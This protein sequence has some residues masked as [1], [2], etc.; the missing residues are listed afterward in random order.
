MLHSQCRSRN[1]VTVLLLAF[2]LLAS[3]TLAQE[4]KPSEPKFSAF[5][6]GSTGIFTLT[7]PSAGPG[8]AQIG[9]V[10]GFEDVYGS[11]SGITFGIEAGI[12]P[13]D[14]G[15]FLVFKAR[16]WEKT[17]SPAISG[18][19]AFSGK[20]DWTQ[21]FYSF[22][23]RYFFVNATSKTSKV[24][25]FAGAGYIKAEAAERVNGTI[26]S[27][28]PPQ[29][30]VEESFVDGS[31]YYL[32]AGVTSYL[33]RSIAIAAIAEY[34]SLSLSAVE[35]SSRERIEID[36]GGGVFVGI[37]ASLFLGKKLKS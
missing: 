36:G 22:G 35:T 19:V 7:F 18:T 34:S 27:I 21:E 5:I 10:I 37:S 30:F 3:S 29:P 6:S 31:G 9:E 20:M 14:M 26:T 16:R 1:N 15:L 25:P 13:A 8:G 11:K 33:D 2:A 12:G 4:E 17:G 28:G 32:E 24:I 23:P